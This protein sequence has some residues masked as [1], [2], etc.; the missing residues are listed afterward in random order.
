MGPRNNKEND[1]EFL[2]FSLFVIIRKLPL[3]LVNCLGTLLLILKTLVKNHIRL[4]ATL[5]Q[6]KFCKN[7]FVLP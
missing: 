2:L 7:V 4:N 6:P 1:L 3:M 5:I